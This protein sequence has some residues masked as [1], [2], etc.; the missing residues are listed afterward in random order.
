MHTW[1]TTSSPACE[2][3]FQWHA[4][5]TPIWRLICS[6]YVPLICYSMI[7]YASFLR[8]WWALLWLQN[9]W[10]CMHVTTI[11]DGHYLSWLFTITASICPLNWTKFWHLLEQEDH[12]CS[13]RHILSSK[14]VQHLVDT[15]YTCMFTCTLYI[16]SSNLPFCGYEVIVWWNLLL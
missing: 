10:N 14:M 2:F 6:C 3:V 15:L 12:M 13:I 9:E 7:L 4:S 11:L 1:L 16:P 8:L 5:Y